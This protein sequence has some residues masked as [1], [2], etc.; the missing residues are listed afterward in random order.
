MEPG[1]VTILGACL[2][3]VTCVVT[4]AGSDSDFAWLDAI[5]RVLMVGAPIGVGVYARRRPPFERFGALLIIAGLGWFVTTLAESSDP[6]LYS[7]GRVAG[8]IVEVGLI[9]LVLAFPLG[10]LRDRTDRALVWA[11]A[12]L[13]LVLYLPTALLVEQYPV[14]ATWTSCHAGCPGN[15]FMVGGSEP[16][17]IGD[18]VL[19]L[20]E[21]LTALLF[22]AVAGR[23]AL[24]IRRATPLTRRALAPVLVV[25]C[26]RLVAYALA[27]MGR[28]IWPES[29]LLEVAVWLVA[30]GIPLMA[31][32]FLLGLWRWRLYIATATLRLAGR[33]RTHPPPDDLRAALAEAFDDRSL[34]IAYWLDGEGRWGDAAGQP[35]ALPRPGSRRW[36]TEVRDGERLVAMVI[37]D[38]ALR[39][40]RAFIDAATSY[41]VLTLDNHRL[42]AQTALLLREVSE[43]R[44]RIQRSADDERRRIERDLHDGAQQRLVALRITLVLA[45]EETD[46][47]D[48]ER[49]ERLRGLGAEVELAIDDVRSLA[50]GIDPPALADHGLVAGLRS[51]ALRMPLPT[52][53]H[54]DGV[55]RYPREVESAAYFCCLEALQNAAK[56]ARGATA[57]VVE[58]SDGAAL[59]IEVRDDGAGFDVDAVTPGVGLVSM[60]DRLATVGGALAVVTGP[61]EGTR[62]IATIPPA[63]DRAPNGRASG[64][65]EPQRPPL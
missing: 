45:A 29:G 13:V 58:L 21:T 16:A 6:V 64:A 31:G 26:L 27:I 11:G 7:T 5:A 53:V 17:V 62:V 37:H 51:A 3:A 1:V 35:M 28:R 15:A 43:S 18:V 41:A 22:A 25:A 14:P 50:R 61:G 63:V 38:V 32:A 19:P 44:A 47:V 36:S 20:R 12:A 10:R 52:T 65:P 42:S 55:G 4:L 46:G 33:L 40:D 49:A 60:R 56:H 24:R 57:A 48:A 54:A 23:L 30:L 2:C 9:Y 8:W 39:D 34:E 59:R